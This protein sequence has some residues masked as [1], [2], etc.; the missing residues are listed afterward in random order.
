[1]FINYT[2]KCRGTL[3][4]SKVAKSSPIDTTHR[5]MFERKGNFQNNDGKKSHAPPKWKELFDRLPCC[6]PRTSTFV[7]LAILYFWFFIFKNKNVFRGRRT[8]LTP[9]LSQPTIGSKHHTLTLQTFEFRT[10]H[11]I[12]GKLTVEAN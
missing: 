11:S 10:E 6:Y 4:C 1:M 12:R 8:G 5:S 2:V 3:K 9:P 7:F